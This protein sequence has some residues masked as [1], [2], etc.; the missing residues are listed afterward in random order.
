MPGRAASGRAG[1]SG[2]RRGMPYRFSWSHWLFRW[3]PRQGPFGI[4]AARTHARPANARPI[5]GRWP[6]AS[7]PALACPAASCGGCGWRTRF[8]PESLRWRPTIRSEPHW[9]CPSNDRVTGRTFRRRWRR[10]SEQIDPGWQQPDFLRN[11]EEQ[12]WQWHQPAMRLC[13]KPA[14]GRWG[15]VRRGGVDGRGHW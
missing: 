10:G 6:G 9:V 1:A 13:R 11:L 12:Q 15:D 4:S 8:W 14:V 7:A 5:C 2:C 3:C